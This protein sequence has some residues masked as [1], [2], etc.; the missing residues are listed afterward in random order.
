M[1]NDPAGLKSAKNTLPFLLHT[2]I[3]D[4]G[5]VL[6]EIALPIVLDGRPWG[7]LRVGFDPNSLL[8]GIGKARE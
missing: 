6:S 7:A 4:T 5:E 8:D 2:Y 1:F 3:R